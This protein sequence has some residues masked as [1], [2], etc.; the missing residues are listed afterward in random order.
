MHVENWRIPLTRNEPVSSAQQSNSARTAGSS[1]TSWEKVP[2]YWTK[3]DF[4]TDLSEVSL[5]SV[6]ADQ[7]GSWFVLVLDNT[8]LWYT[9]RSDGSWA[10][11]TS[12][13]ALLKYYKMK[14]KLFFLLSCSAMDWLAVFGLDAGHTLWCATRNADGVRPN[15]WYNVQDAIVGR[16]HNAI[17]PIQFVSCG[18]DRGDYVH[19]LALDASRTLWWTIQDSDRNW[20][21]PWHRVQD[22][23]GGSTIGPINM[24]SCAVGVHGFLHVF[25]L[26]AAN[27]LWYTVRNSDWSWQ[28]SWINVQETMERNGLPVI[29]PTPW[30]AAAADPGLSGYVHVLAVSNGFKLWHT[31][32]DVATGAWWSMPWENVSALVEPAMGP[33][34]MADAS[35]TSDGSLQVAAI[36]T[37]GKL[38][39]ASRARGPG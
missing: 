4:R 31:A 18:K 15:D 28:Q 26:D 37:A 25:A 13:V 10:E 3:D 33:V 12:E 17:G 9:I 23:M 14:G 32:P 16:G 22:L 5:A 20:Y 2:L 38:W 30:I 39:H 6:S 29:G 7:H 36:D 19:V 24:V 27:I 1:W 8:E 21:E 11:I 35:V 34:C